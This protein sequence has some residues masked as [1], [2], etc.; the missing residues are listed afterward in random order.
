M[1]YVPEPWPLGTLLLA[2]MQGLPVPLSQGESGLKQYSFSP[3]PKSI[4]PHSPIH[5]KFAILSCCMFSGTNSPLT[6]SIECRMVC[7]TTMTASRHELC[8]KEQIP[9]S[10]P[11]RSSASSKTTSLR[12][13]YRAVKHPHRTQMAVPPSD[14]RSSGLASPHRTALL[15]EPCAGRLP[16][17]LRRVCAG[18][19]AVGVMTSRLGSRP[20]QRVYGDE[21]A[22]RFSFG[23]PS[24]ATRSQYFCVPGKSLPLPLLSLHF[25][26]LC[27]NSCTLATVLLINPAS[28]TPEEAWSGCMGVWVLP[29]SSSPSAWRFRSRSQIRICQLT[30]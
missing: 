4:V 25:F 6:W 2:L 7:N 14:G 17:A 27:T 22:W 16:C 24:L 3:Y 5:P 10:L 20:L 21:V 8:G 26:F 9:R 15:V 18:V 30:W 11:K 23:G 13:I 29:S 12:R 19:L 1:P 28:V